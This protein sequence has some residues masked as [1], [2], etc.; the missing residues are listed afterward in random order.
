MEAWWTAALTGW[1]GVVS[2]PGLDAGPWLRGRGVAVVARLEDASDVAGL[3]ARSLC[4]R[5]RG[6]V[7]K[8]GG[9]RC[10]ARAPRRRRRCVHAT[11]WCHD[12]AAGR[13]RRTGVLLGSPRGLSS[14]T[15]QGYAHG[16]LLPRWK[17]AEKQRMGR[18]AAGGGS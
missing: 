2:A 1:F 3:T 8:N 14:V 9:A 4:D 15:H 18:A 5:A 12:E 17:E 13:T 6:A 7:A 11:R 10:R 16:Y